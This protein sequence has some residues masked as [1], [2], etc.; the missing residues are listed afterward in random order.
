MQASVAAVDNRGMR[1][2]PWLARRVLHF[3]HQG[4]ELEAP[5][6]TLY[7]FK[8]G[9][10]KGAHALELD[11]HATQ[12]G[13]IVVS[14]DPTVDRCT[15]GT[16]SI[17]SLTLAQIRELDAAHWFVPGR[18]AQTDGDDYPLRGMAS[19][20]REPPDGFSREDFRIPTLREVL[21]SFPGVVVNMDIKRTEPEVRPYEDLVARELEEAGR[22]D[23]VIVASFHDS[24]IKRFRSL[25]PGV[26][27]A[28][29]LGESADF[30]TALFAGSD[31]PSEIAYQALQV[32]AT[33]EDRQLVTKDFVDRAHR[34]GVAVHVWTVND[35]DEMRALIDMGVDG[36]MS[37]RPSV[38][39]A[40]LA[41]T[42]A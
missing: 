26:S 25:L 33:Y 22:I 28:A 24:A 37:A 3:A 6:N 16:G 7:A 11:V 15:N 39:A 35:A 1:D 31:P 30:F 34:S 4:G 38:C 17:D 23:D 41:S 21:D 40:V 36:L 27:T 42:S 9:L 14:H 20:D 5:S 8:T 13:E 32:P 29:A 10:A 19:G 12:D 2:N 18:D